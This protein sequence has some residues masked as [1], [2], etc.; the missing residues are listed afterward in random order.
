MDHERRAPIDTNHAQRETL[1]ARQSIDVAQWG[2]APVRAVD[3]HASIQYAL[4][5][6]ARTARNPS[7]NGEPD[8]HSRNAL[9]LVCQLAWRN[10]LRIEQLLVL[11]KDEWRHL[12]E[13]R[14]VARMDADVTLAC[15][16]TH[17]IKEFYRPSRNS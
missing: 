14:S 12:P 10:N 7:L 13:V 4:R 6:A 15:V 11:L 17:C 16:V 2:D 9:D 3:L 8:E 1:D 5:S